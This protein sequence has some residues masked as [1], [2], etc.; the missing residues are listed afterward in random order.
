MRN[1]A[2]APAFLI[3]GSFALAA[4]APRID[5]DQP[6]VLS[7]LKQEHPQ[8]Y[9]AVSA[10]LR[11]A[12]HAPCQGI[13]VEL[14][15][16]RFNV[17]DLECGMLLMTSYPAKRHV[18]FELDGINYTATVALQDVEALQPISPAIDLSDRAKWPLI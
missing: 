15:K 8:R 2:F 10:V 16:T 17:R 12:E 9:Q 14:L 1:F 11:A 4:G 3:I 7:Q 18:G 13:E 6:G 5:L